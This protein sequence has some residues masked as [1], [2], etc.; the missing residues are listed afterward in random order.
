MP[1]KYTLKEI[2]SHNKEDSCWIIIKGKVYDI[3]EYLL[4]HPGGSEIILSYAGKDATEF[5]N[6]I[7]A[8]VNYYIK[9]S[10]VL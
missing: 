8:E 9:F 2:S 5:F 1:Q 7:H 4:D 3:T 10:F 6:E